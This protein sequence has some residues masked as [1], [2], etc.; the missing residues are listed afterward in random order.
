MSVYVSTVARPVLVHSRTPSR[1]RDVNR[2]AVAP[3]SWHDVNTSHVGANRDGFRPV[4]PVKTHVM[5]VRGA[6]NSCETASHSTHYF[7]V[8]R[9]AEDD[10]ALDRIH[11]Y[12]T[13]TLDAKAFIVLNMTDISNRLLLVSSNQSAYVLCRNKCPEGRSQ[14]RSRGAFLF[15]SLLPD[16]LSL[17]HCRYSGALQW[18]V[19][20]SQRHCEWRQCDDVPMCTN[21]GLQVSVPQYQWL[22]VLK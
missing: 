9:G 6:Y 15:L 14:R 17:D 13:R 19:L 1:N 12:Y 20:D 2:D 10:P 22:Q 7:T 18:N 11:R 5:L 4:E 8:R 3:Q 16:G 21:F